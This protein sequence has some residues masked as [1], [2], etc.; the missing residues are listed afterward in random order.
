[1]TTNLVN[2]VKDMYGDYVFNPKLPVVLCASY[3]DVLKKAS[4]TTSS[5]I[6]LNTTKQVVSDKNISINATFDPKLEVVMV[7]NVDLKGTSTV[8]LSGKNYG[9]SNFSLLDGSASFKPSGFFVEVSGE[10]IKVINFSMVNVKCGLSDMDYICVKTSAKGFQMY[11]SRLN[12]KT[13]N[14]VFL[15]LDFPLNNYI[16][17]CVFENFGRVSASNGGEMIRMAT[18]QYEKNEANAVI[19]QCYFNK[20]LGD[21]EVVS[22][23]CSRNT[24]KNCIFENNDSSKLVLRHA[25]N[26]TVSGC[27][28]SGSGMRVYGTNHVIENVQVVNEANILLDNKS[29]SSYVKATN[30][31]VTDVYY[32]NVKTPVTNNGINCVVKNVVKGLKITKKDLMGSSVS[33][34]PDPVPTPDTPDPTTP[35]PDPDPTVP[36]IIII[37]EVVDKTK[38][39]K[40]NPDLTDA[41]VEEILDQFELKLT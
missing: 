25:H 14:G 32:D 2:P 41:Q 10:N 20:C 36:K 7:L 3:E 1:M 21:P 40:L 37:P 38:I 35:T 34:T 17:C 18:S 16:K 11:N 19:D 13:N 31:K 33:P 39:Y 28:F 15:R 6:L 5:C 30:V 24:I 26:V 4:T 22:V 12:G 9:V 27:Y 8:K 23:K 29:G